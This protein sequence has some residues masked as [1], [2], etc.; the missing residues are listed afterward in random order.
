MNSYF[1]V[2]VRFD[3]TME[4]GIIKKVTEIYLVDALSFT[5]AETRIVDYAQ[6]YLLTH[7]EFQVISEK[8]TNI[9]DVVTTTESAADK[10]YK[11]KHSI[12]SFNEK[13]GLEKK[14]TQY[15]IVQAASNDNARD[16][17]K[18]FVKGWL[19]DVELEAVSDTKI[20]DYIPY[21]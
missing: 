13:T 14:L 11:V 4:N 9:S 16:R 6:S 5:E 18:Q 1:E 12:I 8:R 20:V 10:Y 15:I 3:K 21:E 7:G 2:G 17:Y 19:G